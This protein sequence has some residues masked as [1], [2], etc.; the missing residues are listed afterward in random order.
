MKKGSVAKILGKQGIKEREEKTLSRL[1]FRS[2]K[3]FDFD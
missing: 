1:F 3:R 2:L